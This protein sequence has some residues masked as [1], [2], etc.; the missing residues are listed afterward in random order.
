MGQK[1]PERHNGVIRYFLKVGSLVVAAAEIAFTEDNF[2]E[3]GVRTRGGRT[4]SVSLSRNTLFHE[5][6]HQLQ[7]QPSQERDF[8]PV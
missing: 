8:G 5:R 6:D 2:S 3:K 4:A 7:I 1:A